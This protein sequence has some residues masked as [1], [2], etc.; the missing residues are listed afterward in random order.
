M[1]LRQ[2]QTFLTI[3]KQASFTKAA[4]DLGYAQ[5]TVTSQIQTLEE[6]LGTMLF[7]RLGRQI[8]L[9]KDGE[10]LCAY[11]AQILALA[12]EAKD[13]VANS[14][15]PKGTLTIGTAESLC[16]YRL[17]ELFQAFRARCPKVEISLRFDICSDY[18]THLRKNTVDIV[19]F[20]DVPCEEADL[21]THVLFEEPM[22]VIASPDHPLTRQKRVGPQDI[23]GQALIL[24]D[25]GCSYRRVFES[26]LAQA[27][28]KPSSVLGVSSNEVIKRF[29]GDG[30]GIGFLPRVTV[31]QELKN[32][33]LAALVWAGPPFAI[34]AQL[35][36]HKEKWLSPA[37]RTFIELT[38]ARLGNGISII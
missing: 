9:T 22:A 34:K 10:N 16:T 15:V 28:A 20:L 32:G 26:I 2:L 6:E 29:V 27:G 37:L 24:T 33:Q 38:L 12:N 23:H 25:L 4:Q 11:A 14:T 5:S 19:F 13:L 8:K 21:V 30:W 17:P 31:E 18:R 3:A 7:E 1:E 36:Y 35:I